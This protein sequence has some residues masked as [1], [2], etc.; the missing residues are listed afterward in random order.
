MK[1]KEEKVLLFTIDMNFSVKKS[2]VIYKR[3]TKNNLILKR[4]QNS[5][6]TWKKSVAYTSSMQ[7]KLKLKAILLIIAK[8]NINIEDVKELNTI[9]Y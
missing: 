3:A 4:F 5:R 1:K 6:S 9:N 8:N 7:Y 2:N